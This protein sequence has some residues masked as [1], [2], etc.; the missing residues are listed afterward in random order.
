MIFRH[1]VRCSATLTRMTC[2]ARPH[3]AVRATPITRSF[4]TPVQPFSGKSSVDEKI[5]EIQELCV[6]PQSHRLQPC[7]HFLTLPDCFTATPL[8][9][10]NSRSRLKAQKARPFMRLMTALLQR[11]SWE[12]SRECM[13]PLSMAKRGMRS[14]DELG[15][16][17]VSLIKLLR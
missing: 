14:R 17:F 4:A 8:R 11:K 5:E 1:L 7:D 6:P 12:P 13:R 10:T 16:G 9:A 2:L 15:R 3:I